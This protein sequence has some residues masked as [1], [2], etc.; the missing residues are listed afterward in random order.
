MEKIKP[1]QIGVMMLVLLSLLYFGQA[2]WDAW[3]NGTSAS[4]TPDETSDFL[5]D[6]LWADFDDLDQAVARIDSIAKADS[7]MRIREDSMRRVR[8]DSIRRVRKD[9]LRHIQY[10]SLMQQFTDSLRQ[11]SAIA[12]SLEL[13]QPTIH[14]TKN[15]RLVLDSIFAGS[16]S[17]TVRVVHYG[18]SQ[19]EEDRISISLRRYLQK[20]YGGGGV[21]ILPLHQTVPTRTVR[22]QLTMNDEVQRAKGGP[23]RYLVYGPKAMRRNTSL[24]GPMGQVAMMDDSLEAGSEDI[25]W[26]AETRHKKKTEYYFSRVHIWGSQD[27]VV[28]L[29]DSST[30][31][32]LHLTGPQEIYGISL[33]TPTGVQVDNIP[34][35]GC[36][37]YIFCQIDSTQ[38]ARYYRE[39]NTRLIIL[40]FGGN[41]MP[42]MDSEKNVNAYVWEMRRHVQYLKRIAPQAV[43]LFIGPSD[44]CRRKEGV[45]QTY[46]MLPVLDVALRRMAKKEDI[47]YWSL[48]EAMGGAGSMY[49]WM[50]TGKACQDGV[51]FTPQGAD[52]AGEMLWKWM[53]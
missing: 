48:Y 18:D 49:E 28:V 24:Y 42:H 8:C 44:M 29:P 41:M 25:I 31:V 4:T 40:Q 43:L 7:L 53:Q 6:S 17:C 11:D 33:E 45:W 35:R 50:Q 37:G 3:K 16:D 1:W 10:D 23:K 15:G 14:F 36:S 52:I 46:E 38:L 20:R 39:T 34:M 30:S 47:C 22:Q 12:D 27:S 32:T 51:H 21:G 9:S 13:P 26:T 2:Y 5:S 19:I